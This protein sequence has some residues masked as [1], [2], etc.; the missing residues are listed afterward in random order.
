MRLNTLIK[1]V[2]KARGEVMAM[3]RSA[4]ELPSVQKWIVDA[5][6]EQL[7]EGMNANGVLM[8]GGVYSHHYELYRRRKGLP[9]DHV[10]LLLDGGLQEGMQVEYTDTGFSIKSTDWKQWMVDFTMETGHWP[11]GNAPEYGP[12]FGLTEAKKGELARKIAPMV[13]RRVRRRIAN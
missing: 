12:V 9:T 10:Y 7:S 4:C 11:P 3:V 2:E 13:A 8:N 5:N 6:K 1:R